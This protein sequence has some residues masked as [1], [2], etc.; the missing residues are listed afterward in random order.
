[1]STQPIKLAAFALAIT[2]SAAWFAQSTAAKAKRTT[3]ANVDLNSASEK[4]LDQLPGVGPATARKII[5]GRPYSAVS[6]L[7]R[8]GLSKRQIDQIT[9]LVTVSSPSSGSANRPAETALVPPRNAPQASG[10]QAAAPGPGVVWVNTKTR[11]YHRPGD[12]FYGKTKYGKYMTE[13]E[14]IQA[15]YKAAKK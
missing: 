9:P 7:S 11:V 12:P 10:T 15:G 1:M 3:T 8:A 13:Q 2:L 14:A 5:A 4:E 6:D